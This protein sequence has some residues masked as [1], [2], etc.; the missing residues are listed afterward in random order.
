M[1]NKF[2]CHLIFIENYPILK[3]II[4]TQ[5][6]FYLSYLFIENYNNYQG[7]NHRI[8]TNQEYYE[9]HIN[10]YNS[11]TLVHQKKKNIYLGNPLLNSIVLSANCR[12]VSIIWNNSDGW[13][14]LPIS[15]FDHNGTS[16]REI[17]NAPDCNNCPSTMLHR[18]KI[19]MHEYNLLSRHHCHHQGCGCWIMLKTSIP[20]KITIITINFA[21][22]WKNMII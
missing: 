6:K 7:K 9:T 13:G 2:L 1:S 21:N 16:F 8:I 17:S 22:P 4:K 18:K 14:I 11:H 12:W 10:L 20:P 15:N 5:A 3:A 19:I